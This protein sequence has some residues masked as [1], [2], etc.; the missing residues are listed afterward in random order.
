MQVMETMNHWSHRI[1]ITRLSIAHMKF[2][3]TKHR[4]AVVLAMLRG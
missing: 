2:Q 1:L 4:D 3:L